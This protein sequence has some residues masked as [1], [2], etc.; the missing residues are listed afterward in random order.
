M[1]R[2]LSILW[3]KVHEINRVH[4]RSADSV[5]IKIYR[6]KKGRGPDGDISDGDKQMVI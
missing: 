4:N 5:V 6:A 2:P 3:S 1:N